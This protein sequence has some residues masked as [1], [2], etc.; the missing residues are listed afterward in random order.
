MARSKPNYSKSLFLYTAIKY[1]QENIINPTIKWCVSKVFQYS[2]TGIYI[3][4]DICLKMSV[5]TPGGGYSDILY[6][7]R[8]GSFWGVKIL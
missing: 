2:I 7:H 4:I 3:G 6:I 5:G 8:L 1:D